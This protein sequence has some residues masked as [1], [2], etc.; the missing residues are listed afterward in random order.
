[1]IVSFCPVGE[2]MKIL[3]LKWVVIILYHLLDGPKRFGELE[4]SSHVSGRLLA[5]RLRDL[6]EAGMVTRTLYPE[7]P[8]RV[9][10]ALTEK[11]QAL[12]PVLMEIFK[13]SNTWLAPL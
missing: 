2:A 3:G 7:I 11:G 8:P 5:E 9:E 4:A 10:Y 6:E 1:M 12:K 13:W